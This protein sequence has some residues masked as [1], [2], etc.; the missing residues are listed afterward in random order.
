MTITKKISTGW[1]KVKFFYDY[2]VL[3]ELTATYENGNYPVENMLNRLEGNYY[4]SS[5]LNTQYIT[6]TG[7]AGNNQ[8]VDYIALYGHNLF[9][10]GA[11]LTL[12]YSSDNFS[13]DINDA[14]TGE[15]PT[16]DDY[17]LKEFDSITDDYWRLKITGATSFPKITIGY[18]GEATELDWCNVSFDPNSLTD[19]TIVNRTATGFVTGLYDTFQER[20]QNFI[21]NQM[22]PDI[23]EKLNTW[24][25]AVGRQN[26]LTGWDTTDHPTEIYLMYWDGVWNNPFSDGG[27]YR[28]VNIKLIGRVQ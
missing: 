17:Y 14:F 19:K 18:W 6:D 24:R 20:S 1:A 11:T 22:E 25:L 28:N 8:T 2:S 9:S 7:S 16:T 12:Q 27:R 3:M 26:F 23:Y 4:L 15:T 10:A 13:A 5:S 21:W